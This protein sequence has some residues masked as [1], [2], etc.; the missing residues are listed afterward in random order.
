MLVI[1]HKGACWFIPAPTWMKY[2]DS[3][4]NLIFPMFYIAKQQNNN[5]VSYVIAISIFHT[6]ILDLSSPDQ[7]KGRLSCILLLNHSRLELPNLYFFCIA[8]CYYILHDFN[9]IIFWTDWFMWFVNS[10]FLHL[11]C[12]KNQTSKCELLKIKLNIF[13]HSR[14]LSN[15][16]LLFLFRFQKLSL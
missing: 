6:S 13:H 10:S 8:N 11:F 14:I 12:Q 5:K 3:N 9:E 4:T 1:A 2:F 15:D 7:N 16:K